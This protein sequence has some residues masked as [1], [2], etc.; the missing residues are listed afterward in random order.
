MSLVLERDGTLR[1]ILGGTRCALADAG[2]PGCVDPDGAGPLS[3]GDAQVSEPWGVAVGASG[4]VYVADTW[5]G[6]VLVFG[7]D[8]SFRRKWGR[9]GQPAPGQDES[10]TPALYGPR[11]LALDHEGRLIVAD[12]GNK[13]VLRFNPTGELVDHI[14]PTFATPQTFDEPTAIA[15]DDNQTV[16]VADAWNRRIVRFDRFG[17]TLT[18]WRVPGWTSR[19]AIDKPS[20]AVDDRGFVYATDPGAG[21][22]FVFTPS[23]TVSAVVRV[24]ALGV[25]SRDRPASRLIANRAPC[26]WPISTAAVC[27]GCRCIRACAESRQF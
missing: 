23:G 7:A 25:A 21:R 19:E 15:A 27:W 24:P 9:F 17:R 6:R 2:Q 16:L 3:S 20:I 11:G 4:D 10:T 14:A 1:R 22:V 13:R 8:G 5:N 12:T 26:W 18:T